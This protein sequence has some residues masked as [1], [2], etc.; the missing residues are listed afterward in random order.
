MTIRV[1][2]PEGERALTEFLEFRDRVYAKRPVRWPTFAGL[3]LPMLQGE[4]PF[5]E[6]RRFRPFFAL[7]DGAPAARAVAMVDDR[8]IEHW[9][10][11]LGHVILFEAMPDA[12]EAAVAV[13][14]AASL[15]LREQGMEAVR[16]GYGNQEF[17]F[18]I[19]DYE[20]LPAGFMRHNPPEYHAMF[21]DAG[22]E[23]ELGWV[24][25]KIRVTPDLV[26]RY[27]SAVENARRAGY[28]LVWLA[29]IPK[30]QRITQFVSLWN[31]AF[32]GHWG[33]SPFTEA[34]FGLYFDL[35]AGFGMLE[36]SVI[37][38][39]EGEPKGVLWITPD[40]SI[41]AIADGRP[42]RD[43]EKVNFLGIG[44][45]ESARRTGLNVA[46]A[47]YSYLELIRG[48]ATWLSYTLVRDDNRPS[49]ST[50]EK[51][52]ASVCANFVVYRRDFGPH[53]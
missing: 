4:G 9:N 17:P 19:D 46:M 25:Y 47:S 3:H 36:T 45:H 52:G 13:L 43:D 26:A 23:T 35:L 37:A 39:R 41:G 12:R 53:R 50:A 18:V 8:Y 49:R 33:H 29:D 28:D 15:W 10:E 1:E 14:H 42:L 30:T 51:L 31:H 2:T 48:G 32:A 38:Y 27:E 11:Q 6:R 5:A 7:D 20:S 16:A 34:E 24:D 40:P 21:K 44:V 22:F